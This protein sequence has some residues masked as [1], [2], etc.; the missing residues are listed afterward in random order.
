[1]AKITNQSS[2]TSKYTLPDGTEQTNSVQSNISETENMTLSFTKERTSAKT[3]GFPG[4]SILQTLTLTNSSDYPVENVNITDNISVD[5]S[6][7]SGTLK[8][9]G[10][11]YPDYDISTG[12][13]LPNEIGSQQVVVITYELEIASTPQSD[14]VNVQSTINYS[15]DKVDNLVENSNIIEL[16]IVTEDIIIEKTSTK[17]VVIKGQTLTFKNVVKNN[18][19][20][21]NTEVTFKDDIPDGTTFVPNS[22]YIDDVN[23]PDLDPSVGFR[24]EDL[25]AGAVVT[26]LF[27]VV[28]N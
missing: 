24:L 16:S 20:L 25:V 2:L 9:D 7:K 21:T 15:V 6:F 28:I 4:D 17:T 27:D 11:P 18:G 13:T 19:S 8:I 3:Y 26:I 14:I 23:K 5:G 10:A 22:V 12:I 1:M